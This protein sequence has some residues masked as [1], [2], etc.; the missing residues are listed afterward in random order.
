[1]T[2]VATD[3]STIQQAFEQAKTEHSAP[4]E[5]AEPAV[6]S[7]ESPASPSPDET[8]AASPE[9]T[10]AD[11]TDR[12]SDLISDAELSALQLT[13]KDDPAALAKA[14][15]G[16]YTQKTQALAE[17]RKAVADLQ[18]H[19]EFLRAFK[20]D[21]EGTLRAEAARRGLQIGAPIQETKAVEQAKSVVDDAVAQFKTALGPDLDFLGD[22]LAPA[23]KAMAETI[24]K[25]TVEHATAPLKSAQ[26]TLLTKAA[27]EQT[28]AVMQ[29]FAA[30]H[31]DW[32]QHEPAMMKIAATLKPNGMAESEYLDTLYTLATLDIQ[33]AEAVKVATERITRV[34]KTAETRTDGTP[35]KRVDTSSRK[36]SSIAEAFA[37]AKAEAASR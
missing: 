12:S 23:V 16:R 2:A 14:L 33:K 30:K 8:P 29:A 31:P 25:Q 37:E 9:T 35:E 26:D 34:A 17:E 20:T 22:A 7:P 5:R 27:E 21:P 4:A 6:A 18:Q 36:V 24:A 10:T 11:T 28:T 13:H 19:A 1:M 32:T 15:K 3:V